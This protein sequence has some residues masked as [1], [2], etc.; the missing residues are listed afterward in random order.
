MS[1]KNALKNLVTHFGS[2]W[3][4]LAYMLM[5]AALITGLSL[6]F[7]MPIVRAF[8]EAGVGAHIRDAYGAVFG[9]GGFET[10]VDCLYAAYESV[11][12]VFESNDTVA[13]LTMWFL[14]LVVIVAF[15]FFWGLHEIPLAT[16]ID[17]A[18]SCNCHYGFFGKFISGLW[19]SVRYSFG[20]M[21]FTVTVDAAMLGVEYGVI[22][23]LGNRIA[24][25]FVMMVV[26]LVF[27][28]FKNS[29]TACWAP[30]VVNENYGVARAF[31][32]GARISFR[33]FGAVF[34]M[35]FVSMLLIIAIG[36][37]LAVFTL[38][39]GLVIVI[40]LF[41]V[42]YGFL[43]SAIFYGKLGKRYYVDGAV[44]TPIV[45]EKSVI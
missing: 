10:A 7:I 44:F 36:L 8:T 33:N 35:I 43:D 23:G 38:G 42:Y 25:P 5:F 17:G 1:V 30:C 21:L 16:V 19:I 4:L 3:A 39:V 22:V 9:G 12:Y 18:M 14:I 27:Q 2:V 28:S 41:N 34:S 29:A 15:R 24:L 45:K 40:P 20:K 13:S 37:F 32:R 6:P 11:I 26:L 31:F